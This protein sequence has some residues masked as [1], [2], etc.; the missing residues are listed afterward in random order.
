MSPWRPIFRRATAIAAVLA[1]FLAGLV[2]TSTAVAERSQGTKQQMN[3]CG[4][5]FS[6]VVQAYERLTRDPRLRPL[7]TSQEYINLE[8][9]VAKTLWTFTREIHSAHPAVICRDVV[10]KNGQV[11]IEMKVLCQANKSSCDRL[12]DAFRAHNQKII[13]RTGQQNK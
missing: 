3:L 7:S 13:R 11:L 6:S 8:N 1:L 9:K 2:A 10:E 4:R 5:T 12:V